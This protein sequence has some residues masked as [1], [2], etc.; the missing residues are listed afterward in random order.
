MGRPSKRRIVLGFASASA[1]AMPSADAVFGPPWITPAAPTTS[2]IVSVSIRGGGCDAIV[3]RPGYP[4][5]TRNG[6]QLRV[7]EY[8]VRA[9][10]DWCIYPAGTYPMPIGKLA[11]GDYTLTVDFAHDGYPFGLTTDTLGVIPFYRLGCC[12][13]N[14]G[15]IADASLEVR[16]AGLRCGQRMPGLGG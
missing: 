13:T 12:A 8:G 15:S 1:F 4:Q 14:P 16:A 5:V 10:Q 3:E 6:N 7:V 11:A 2:D 9:Y